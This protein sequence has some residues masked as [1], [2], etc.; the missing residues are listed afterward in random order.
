[1]LYDEIIVGGGSSGMVLAARL[2]E[3]PMRK[4]LLLEGGPCF[5]G[6]NDTPEEILN[7]DIPVLRGYNWKVDGYIKEASILETLSDSG[8]SLKAANSRFSLIKT[9]VKS[10]L[11]G[12]GVVGRFDYPVGRVLGGSSSVNG[13]IALRAMPADFAEWVLRGNG[14][15]NWENVVKYFVKLEHDFDHQNSYHGQKG[16]LPIRHMKPSQFTR[17]QRSFYETCKEFGY[18]ETDDF[19]SPYATGVGGFPKNIDA[20][21]NRISSALAS[22]EFGDVGFRENL[23]IVG[24]A[25]VNR[26]I[27]EGDCAVGIECSVAGRTEKFYGDRI[28]LTAGFIHSPAILMRSGIGPEKDLKR[29]SIPVRLDLAGVG[30][31]LVDHPVASIWAVPKQGVCPLGEMTHQAT[32]RYSSR[33]NK[34]KDDM[35]L[36]ML[37]AFDVSKVPD[38]GNLLNGAK[39]TMALSAVV[40]TPYSTGR[41]HMESA[42]PAISPRVYANLLQEPEDMERMVE[43]VQLAWNIMQQKSMKDLIDDIPVWHQKVIDSKSRVEQLLKTFVRGSSHAGGTAKMGADTDAMAVVDQYGRVHG[44]RNL[45]VVDASIMP[46]TVRTPTSVTCMMMAELVADSMLNGD[47]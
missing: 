18:P 6:I 23:H 7:H 15:W 41:I 9:A 47:S 1:M 32:L 39:E 14:V 26:V 30:Q 25:R 45:R 20:K 11:G 19:N 28:S 10:T 40:G 36:F 34:D 22:L 31:N 43:G 33:L 35:S 3:D 17:V 16:T 38:L 46:A 29:L 13:A 44:G 24:K 37:S 12:S 2:S 42:D 8:K 27:F 4:V 5:S 21:G